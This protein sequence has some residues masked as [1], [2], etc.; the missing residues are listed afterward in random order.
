MFD[1]VK[2]T[3]TIYH[4][5][6]R[7]TRWWFQIFFCSPL[8][9]V[10]NPNLTHIFQM[11]LVQPPTRYRWYLSIW[12]CNVSVPI[13]QGF[14][15]HPG[16]SQNQGE[17]PSWWPKAAGKFQNDN[18]NRNLW[19]HFGGNIHWTSDVFLVNLG[20]IYGYIKPLYKSPKLKERLCKFKGWT[21]NFGWCD[22]KRSMA[23]GFYL[24]PWC[25]QKWLTQR[26]DLAIL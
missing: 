12:V 11:G 26:K 21:V 5:N 2:C 25:F 20:V 8:L 6:I 1:I 16:W 3:A 7:I 10:N 24:G 13:I 14:P 22:T 18:R 23:L 17:M 15:R 4:V 19:N 9:R